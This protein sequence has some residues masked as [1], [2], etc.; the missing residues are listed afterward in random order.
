MNQIIP[1][2]YISDIEEAKWAHA[3]FRVLNVMWNGE[4][5]I[6]PRD[7]HIATTDNDGI[8][9]TK[10]I[11]IKMDEAADWIHQGLEDGDDVLVHCYYGIERSPLTVVWYLMRHKGMD[12][13]AAYNL[14]M[15][16][17][18]QAQYR[19]AWLPIEVKVTGSL[20]ERGT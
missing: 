7:Y 20:P 10:A 5:G 16:K 1:H 12:L 15:E 6:N 4:D 14:V 9:G 19:G 17:H 13:T 3:R 18:P 11:P 8:N 2:L